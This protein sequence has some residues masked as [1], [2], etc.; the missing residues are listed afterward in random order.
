[1]TFSRRTIHTRTPITSSLSVLSLIAPICIGA[2]VIMIVLSFWVSAVWS[3]LISPGTYTLDRWVTFTD[4]PKVFDMDITLWR[5]KLWVKYRA[6]KISNLQA[7]GYRV[8]RPMMLR[9]IFSTVLQ[10]PIYTDL[11]I[12]ILPWWNSYDIDEYLYT[13]GIISHPGDFLLTLR[14]N[15]SSYRQTYTFL[16]GVSSVEGFLVPDTYRI[17]KNADADAVIRKMLDA[18]ESRIAPTYRSLGDSGYTMM[19]LASIVER[20][21]RNPSIKP[22][23]AGI[24]DKR[25]REW[26]PMWA[27]ATVCFGYAKTQKQ[28]T[29]SFISDVIGLKHPYN[30]R[31]KQ[32]YPPTPISTFSLDTWESVLGKKDSPYYYYLHDSQGVIHYARTLEEHAENKRKYL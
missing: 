11:T 28:C 15:F 30:T 27:D 29:P 3:L 25:V 22:I 21:E 13:K 4:L 7:W 24:L 12:T 14:E 32:G 18:F 5:Y 8:D 6:P 19:I 31:N 10:K 16:D 26:I 2:C 23:V 17:S 1:M 9:D 20:E